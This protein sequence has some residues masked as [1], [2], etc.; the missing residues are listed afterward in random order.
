[1]NFTT[2]YMPDADFVTFVKG[3]PLSRKRLTGIGGN[4]RWIIKDEDGSEYLLRP[5]SSR[6]KI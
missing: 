5:E 6:K 3:L 4:N 2:R 1:M